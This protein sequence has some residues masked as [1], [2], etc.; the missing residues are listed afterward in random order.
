MKTPHAPILLA[1]L[2]VALPVQAAFLLVDDMEG[3]NQWTGDGALVADPADAGN[4]VYAVPN[5][6]LQS[7]YRSLPTIS[8]G[9]ATLFFRARSTAAGSAGSELIDWVLG[10]SDSAAPNDWGNYEGYIRLAED[11]TAGDL[12]IDVRNGGGFSEVG[13]ISPDVWYNVWLVLNHDAQ[14]TDVYFNTGFDDA[15]A[16][17]T[18]SFSG[19]AFRRSAG[20]DLVSFFVRN[21]EADTTGYVDDI[22]LDST[23]QNLVNPIPEPAPVML[24]LIGMAGILRRRR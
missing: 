2:A 18:S 12:D 10:T 6:G 21:N 1:S 7:A 13:P 14:T 17:G 20:N 22:Y 9:T 8:S 23:G 5:A 11:G 3:T 24:G 16:G 15:T 19:A 4:M